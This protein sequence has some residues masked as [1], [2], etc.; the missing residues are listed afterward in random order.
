[1][2]NFT[3][4]T[5]VKKIFWTFVPLVIIIT[6]LSFFQNN[7]QQIVSEKTTVKLF[8]YNPAL[9]QGVGGVQCTEKGLVLVSRDIPKTVTPLAESVK[10]LLKGDIT[11]QEKSK[12][13]SSEFPLSGL[14]LKSATIVNG[15]ATLTFLDPQNKTTGGSCRTAIL[16]Q[17]I[18]A[19]AMQF[20]SVNEVRFL[21]EDLFQP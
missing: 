19:T 3:N 1:M 14:E 21:P 4:L 16:W 2:Q 13:V 7:K 20:D 15:V 17:Q 10:L 9:D 11:E 5:L 18:K 8:Y 12:G 6:A